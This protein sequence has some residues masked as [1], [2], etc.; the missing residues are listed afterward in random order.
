LVKL[1]SVA[2][3]TLEPPNFDDFTDRFRDPAWH[4]VAAD[5][6]ARHGRTFDT[7]QRAEHGEN[8][9]F[10]V[11]DQ[12]VLKIY[13]P[14]KR[15]YARELAGLSF[16]A[17]RTGLAVPEVV[18]CGD[19][20]GY[21]YILMTKVG[22]HA[23]S[24]ADWVRLDTRTQI[25]LITQLADELRRLHSFDADAF[26]FD[27][28]E[29]LRTQIDTAVDKQRTEGGDPEWVHSIPAYFEKH[30]Q[31]IPSVCREA[32]Q[33][34]DVHFGN[35]RLTEIDGKLRFTGL[36][37]FADSIKGFYEYDFI[38]VGVLMIQGQGDLQ[39]EFFGAYGYRDHEIDEQLR[40]RMFLLTML[41]EYSSL[42]RYAER[43]GVDPMNYGLEELGR[44]IWNFA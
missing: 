27:W 44:A 41:Y 20:A 28:E 35:L 30:L 43:L 6:L 3:K 1:S 16:A 13:T 26:P 9:V 19:I 32:F 29:F 12:F 5:V 11:D 31:L 2:A 33:H 8:V 10:L 34:G 39:R 37:D 18:E 40:N 15:G 24:R 36:F 42:R 4:S 38:A 22:A 23:M 7:L 14:R 21:R 25:E 17:G